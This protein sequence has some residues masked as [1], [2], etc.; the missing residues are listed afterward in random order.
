MPLKVAKLDHKVEFEAPREGDAGYDIRALD[1][2][3][4]FAGE[5]KIIRTGLVMEIPPGHVGIL[6]DRSSMA[7]KQLY[8]HS[9]VI[10]AS[11]RGE[12]SVVLENRRESN[13][14]IEPGQRIAQMLLVAVST[15]A[16]L[17]CDQAS[18]SKSLRGAGAFGST[19]A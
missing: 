16:V 14:H 4:L 12:I 10:D 17:I 8:V 9:G 7:M 13:Y 18:L 11:Y 2:C 15:P 6:K 3:T 19:G 5:Q 1:A